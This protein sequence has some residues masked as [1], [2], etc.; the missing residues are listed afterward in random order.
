VII[1]DRNHAEVEGLMGFA[2]DRGRVVSTE[3]EARTL[4]LTPPY[5][6]VSQTTQDEA[7]FERLSRIILNRYPG[8]KLFNTICDATHKRQEEVRE[9]CARVGG[10]VV[11]GGH[12]SANTKRLGE[13]VVSMGRSVFM[14]ETEA[15]LDM[16][17]LSHFD[18]IGVTAGASTPTWMINRVV[19]T[20]EAIPVQGEGKIRGAIFKAIWLMLTSSVFVSLGGG[21]LTYVCDLLQSIQPQWAH[22][23]ISFT[24]L[25]AMHN[26]NRF[27]DQRM[28]KFH[29][30]LRDRFYRQNRSFVLISSALGLA[31]A[32]TLTLGLGR[33]PFFLLLGMS[34]LGVLY[35]VRLIPKGMVPAM[36]VRGLKEIPGS[37]TF[38]VAM[39]WALV[40]TVIPAWGNGGHAGTAT[41]GTLAVVL[42]LAFVRSNLFDVF[43]VQGDRLVGKETLPV[44]IGE[45]MTL[46]FLVLLMGV[47]IL[48]L[49][50]LPLLNLM[51][52]AGVWLIPGVLY[53]LAITGLYERGRVNP[54]PRL[55]LAL[56]TIFP[57]MAGLVWLG[58]L[59]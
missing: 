27:I 12:A 21:L 44:C 54:G 6:I 14:V 41:L 38:F 37:K 5:I 4:E 56:D 25:Y 11:V 45:R 22:G 40:T 59:L 55:E 23:V 30:P 49:L 7:V 15:D 39:A 34:I 42:L 51:N 32:L 16:E 18:C 29:D 43:E 46:V 58:L 52:M 36:R 48:L 57:I 33:R 47:L 3:A 8:G 17:A 9:L 1:G 2:G 20:L 28:K 31:I 53:M 50:L 35:S 19:R 10:V 24:Y 13:I 26:V